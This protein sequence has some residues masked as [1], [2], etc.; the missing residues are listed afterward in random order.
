MEVQA[1]INREDIAVYHTK[2]RMTKKRILHNLPN[3]EEREELNRRDNLKTTGLIAGI[4]VFCYV[5]GVVFAGS[6]GGAAFGFAGLM[7]LTFL[8]FGVLADAMH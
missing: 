1:N 4:L 5:L 7:V 8:M 3:R 6:F 2:T